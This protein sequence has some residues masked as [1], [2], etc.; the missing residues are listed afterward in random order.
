MRSIAKADLSLQR[1]EERL[2]RYRPSEVRLL[3]PERAAV[4]V[5]LRF[6]RAAP[7]VLLMRRV[8][9][10]DDRWSGHVSFPGGRAEP[11]DASLLD[12]AVREA[13]EEV[14]LD[15]VASA[16][17]L[18]RLD[19]I[20]AIAR[21]RFLPMSITPF[22]FLQTR[23]EEPTLGEEAARTFWLP[24]DRVV[25]GDLDDRHVVRF[26][27]VSRAFRCWRFGDDVVWGL[28]YRMIRNLLS[29]VGAA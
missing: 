19:G 18:G 6:E 5:L 24:L 15:L 26:G 1:F 7:D 23:A 28:T 16:R 12:T 29:V 2:S 20:R 17:P 13:R 9:R 22:V 4:A 11:G 14:G 21:G 3:T 27:P 10:A 8:A 25:A